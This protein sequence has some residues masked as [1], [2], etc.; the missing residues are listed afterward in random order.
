MRI[1]HTIVDTQ[2]TTLLNSIKVSVCTIILLF[3]IPKI[4]GNMCTASWV[5]FIIFVTFTSNHVVV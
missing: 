3:N 2:K 5:F 1:N 4:E